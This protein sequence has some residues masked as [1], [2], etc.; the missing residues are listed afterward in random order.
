MIKNLLRIRYLNLLKIIEIYRFQFFIYPLLHSL[1]KED[2]LNCF[3][4]N[5]LGTGEEAWRERG[6]STLIEINRKQN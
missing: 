3:F 5:Y 2:F 6:S 4:I 1:K